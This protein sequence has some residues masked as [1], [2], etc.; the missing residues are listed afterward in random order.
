MRAREEHAPLIAAYNAVAEA[1]GRPQW[2][3]DEEYS[4]FSNH[5]NA[6]ITQLSGGSDARRLWVTALLPTLA[7]KIP[8]LVTV[9]TG[10]VELARETHKLNSSRATNSK[11]PVSK[12]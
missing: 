7:S 10:D 9:P 5:D 6:K 11:F 2:S 4:C 12:G 8:G 1:A 3:D